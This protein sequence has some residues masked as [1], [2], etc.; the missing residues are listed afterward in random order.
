[1]CRVRK[2]SRSGYYEWRTRSLSPKA[3]RDHVLKAQISQHHTKSR[4]TYS[5]RR[6]QHQ[7]TKEQ[8]QVSRRR[9]SRL[10]AEA[11]LK[12]KTRRKFKATTNSNHG[13]PVASNIL[14]RN[15]TTTQS[16]RIY[17][18]RW[19]YLHPH[20]WRVAVFRRLYRPLF[21]CRCWLVDGY[22]HACFIG[23]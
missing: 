3:Q 7:L 6:I 10:M 8:E 9:I 12:C 18:G 4:A 14:G 1:M 11:G 21:S 16:D 17:V 13:K 2:V 20:P 5:V 15:F 22:S 23:V 19:Y